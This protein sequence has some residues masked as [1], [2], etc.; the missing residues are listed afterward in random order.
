[1]QSLKGS[2]RAGAVCSGAR[3][4]SGHGERQTRFINAAKLMLEHRIGPSLL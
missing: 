1:V 3:V 2:D 4:S